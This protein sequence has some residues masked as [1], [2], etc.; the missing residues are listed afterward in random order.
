MFL[1]AALA[2]SSHD[3]YAMVLDCVLA[4]IKKDINGKPITDSNG[5]YKLENYIFKFKNSYKNNKAVE[6]GA[7][8]F[9]YF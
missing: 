8:S 4:D 5:D 6:I 1:V 9:F 3:T 2:C 7:G